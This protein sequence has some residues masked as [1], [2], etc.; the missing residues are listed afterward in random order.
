MGVLTALTLIFVVLKLCGVVAWPW[1]WVISPVILELCF[2]I[3]TIV[4]GTAFV[5]KVGSHKP[6]VWKQ[7]VKR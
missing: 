6:P 3:L 2:F 5:A 1:L 7:G 4:L